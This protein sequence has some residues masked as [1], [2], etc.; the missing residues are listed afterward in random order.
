M[1]PVEWAVCVSV[2][3]NLS[4]AGNSKFN[5]DTHQAIGENIC[6]AANKEQMDPKLFAAYI[7]TEN[8]KF[9]PFSDQP[10]ARGRDRGLYQSNSEFQGAR[11]NYALVAHPYYATEIAAAI[12]R[13]NLAKYGKTWKGI[14]AYWN[15][16]RAMNNEQAAKDYYG[17]WLANFNTVQR[18][19]DEKRREI[20]K[21]DAQ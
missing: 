18:M 4:A 2:L 12:I 6:A 8:R 11:Q 16:T 14:A 9:D 19:F 1:T 7:L 21:K 17:R 3:A 13:E 15:P 5:H 20:S 10:A